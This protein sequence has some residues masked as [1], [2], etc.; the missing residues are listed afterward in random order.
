MP[1]TVPSRPSRGRMLPIITSRSGAC[2]A[3]HCTRPP[4]PPV[5]RVPA[6]PSPAS[7]YWETALTAAS[8]R[9]RSRGW[10]DMSRGGR[11][12]SG[13]RD[14]SGSRSASQRPSPGTSPIGVSAV[15]RARRPARSPTR[16]QETAAPRHRSRISRGPSGR[17]GA[18]GQVEIV[19]NHQGD[20]GAGAG[21]PAHQVQNL[22][23]AGQV[24]VID[25]LVQRQQTRGL[26]QGAGD[27][28]L[29][30]LAAAQF[31]AE[32]PRQPVQTEHRQH[33]TARGLDVEPRDQG[34]TA[35][36][37]GQSADAEHAVRS[38]LVSPG[39]R[40]RGPRR[41][42]PRAPARRAAGAH[43]GAR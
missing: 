42:G 24:Q 43:P 31:R 25:R 9:Q 23:L 32:P 40:A 10:S 28:H 15:P 37:E 3:S 22:V 36:A 21:G 18:Q 38:P 1:S 2:S 19:E 14:Q 12:A 5:G 29:L 33:L 20:Q 4:Q 13:Q 39:R 6:K 26:G 41:A 16:T 7:R 27:Q 8:P 34:R 35:V 11:A 17:S 30:E